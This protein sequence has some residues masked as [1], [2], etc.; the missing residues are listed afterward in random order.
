MQF[1]DDTN[2]QGVCQLIDDLCD[3]DDT[4]FP[5]IKKTR[6]VNRSFFQLGGEIIV[7]DGRWQFEDPNQTDYP[8]GTFALVEGQQLY[9]LDTEYL[10]IEMI[11]ILDKDGFTYRKIKP[12]DHS[13]LGDLSP[14]EYFGITAANTPTK[15]FPTYYDK[16]GRHLRLYPAPAGT[17]VTLTA[18]LRVTFKRNPKTFTVTTGTGADTREPGLRGY[19]EILAYMSSIP[20]CMKYKKDRVVMYQNEVERLKKLLLKLYKFSEPDVR[21]IITGKPILYK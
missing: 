15:G 19:H 8:R 20:Y 12:I 3:S 16:N 4:S 18:G 10:M 13:Q 1:F 11:E 2:K 9:S 17:D 14:D 5:R 21:K 6:E 7:S